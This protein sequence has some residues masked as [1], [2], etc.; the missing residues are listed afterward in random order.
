M[1][2]V[3]LLLIVILGF[4]GTLSGCAA[5]PAPPAAGSAQQATAKPATSQVS[6]GAKVGR[7]LFLDKACAVCHKVRGI[8]S[9]GTAGP[10]LDGFASRPMIAGV[11]PNT[12]EQLKRWLLDPPGVKPG[13]AMPRITLTEAEAVRLVA[14]LQSLK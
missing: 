1:F 9:V 10:A 12:P 13:T 7:D 11:L 5:A 4:A 3:R 8:D 14:F 6:A 2:S